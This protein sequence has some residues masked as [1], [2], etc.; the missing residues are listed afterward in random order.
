MPDLKQIF[1]YANAETGRLTDSDGYEIGS[2]KWPSVYQEDKV[3][4]CI[5]LRKDDG[6]AYVIGVSDTIALFVNNTWDK[7]QDEAGL[8]TVAKSGAVTEI[9]A[10]TLTEDPPTSG[11]LK[12]INATGQYEKVEYTSWTEAAGT[13]TFVVSTTLTYSYQ[14]GDSCQ[15]MTPHICS[16]D[17]SLVNISGDWDDADIAAG[18]ISVRAYFNTIPYRDRIGEL[19]EIAD[20][21]MELVK[22]NSGNPSRL[23]QDGI[24]CKNIVDDELSE[25]VE[26][27]SSF[28]RLDA[29]YL[30]IAESGHYYTPSVN[31]KSAADTT[32]FTVPTG[33]KFLL[34]IVASDCLSITGSGTAHKFKIYADAV[35]VVPEQQS[36][37]AAE[38][39]CDEISVAFNKTFVAG[40]VIKVTITNA[41][42]FTTHTAKFMIFGE[43][44][45]DGT[46]DGSTAT[47]A[48][49]AV[50]SPDGTIW[51]LSISNAGIPTWTPST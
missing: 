24:R 12:L 25:P 36:I 51:T 23:I 5:T 15:I 7:I 14:I 1:I 47:P 41:S 30:K 48:T 9:K 32:I 37:H 33:K 10:N 27:D 28:S 16:S 44:T 31:C 49:V 42:T 45:A 8:L 20:C 39:D 13:Y 26:T 21:K 29:R 17:N 18:K 11:R 40:T 35:E 22:Y 2:D 3:I 6:T 46:R 34:K 19:D 43:L 50:A 38:N 4:F